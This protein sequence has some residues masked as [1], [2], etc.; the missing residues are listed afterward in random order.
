MHADAD[1]GMNVAGG[2]FGVY[3]DVDVVSDVDVNAATD[4]DTDVVV[5]TDLDA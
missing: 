2:S 1:A 5:D 3:V 4:V